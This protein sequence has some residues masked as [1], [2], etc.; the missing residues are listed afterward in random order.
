MTTDTVV[1]AVAVDL[2][3]RECDPPHGLR[4][5][6]SD[7]WDHAADEPYHLGCLTC[8]DESGLT[9]WQAARALA[10]SVSDRRR[11]ELT[12]AL[13]ALFGPTW[14]LGVRRVTQ[15]DHSLS[16]LPVD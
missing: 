1:F 11:D 13:D 8:G 5:S 14:S 6:V 16:D 4:L 2:K 10:S 12:A 3:A 15:A 7:G 9:A